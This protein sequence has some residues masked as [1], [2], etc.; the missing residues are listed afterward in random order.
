MSARWA[1]DRSYAI[2]SW[3][4]MTGPEC[5]WL[6]FSNTAARSS[7]NRR[8]ASRVTSSESRAVTPSR[9][10]VTSTPR[11]PPAVQRERLGAQRQGD[12]LRRLR[13][14]GEAGH[15]QR[16]GRGDVDRRRAGAPAFGHGGS[17]GDARQADGEPG[18]GLQELAAEHRSILTPRFTW[19]SPTPTPNSKVPSLARPD[20]ARPSRHRSVRCSVLRPHRPADGPTPALRPVSWERRS[21]RCCS[22]ARSSRCPRP[23]RRCPAGRRAFPFRRATSCSTRRWTTRLRGRSGCSS[24][25]GVSGARRSSSGPTPAW[26]PPPSAIRAA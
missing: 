2:E 7:P 8:C 24:G 6:A 11:C 5:V 14:R 20:P 4:S 22:A 19:S 26:S 17:A 25:W 10:T 13:P 16:G 21:H 12:A 9:S 1:A 3:S 23:K 15:P 18:N